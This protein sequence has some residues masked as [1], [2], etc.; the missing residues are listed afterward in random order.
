M[1]T[2]FKNHIN[3]NSLFKPD[4]Q[5]L[6][7]V[8]GGID[9]MVM[10]D[11]FLKAKFNIG[12][13]HCN[14]QL[15]GEESDGDE[16]FVKRFATQ[17][18]IRIYTMKFDTEKHAGDHGISIQMAARELRYDW[19]EK[20]RKSKGFKFVSLAHNL[21]DVIETCLINLSRGTG[22]RGLSGIHIIKGNVIRPLLFAGREEIKKYSR[23]NHVQF[24]EDSSNLSV[25][26]TRNRIRHHIIPEFTT[27]NPN[28]KSGI[29]STISNL[30]DVEKIYFNMIE[31]NRKEVVTE[32][33][34]QVAINIQKLKSLEP[35]STYLYEFLRPFNFPNQSVGDIIESLDRIAGKQFYSSTHRLIKDRENLIITKL[36]DEECGLYYIEDNVPR[37]SKPVEMSFKKTVRTENIL[38]PASGR[39]AWVDYDLLEF[40]LILRK[41]KTGDYFQPLG[42]DNSKKLSDF[43]VDSKM[44]IHEKENTWLLTCGKR[45]IWIVG[46]RIDDRFKITDKTRTIL[47]IN[48]HQEK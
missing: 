32:H 15:R 9:S 33:K 29:L 16:T 41:W 47:M 20:I 24:R 3:R 30:S 26:Y 18:K 5:I 8:S 44:S 38:F 43:F 23:E 6:L 21:D 4:D 11:L 10:C 13:A 17:N 36:T 19:F 28:F 25:K 46:R 7:A 22:I 2:E 12:I 37:I 14:F 35:L 34:E 40:P 42:M 48:L 1:L 45:I 39:I 31:R 27:I